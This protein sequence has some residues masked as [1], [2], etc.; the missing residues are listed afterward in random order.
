[1]VVP[2][3]NPVERVVPFGAADFSFFRLVRKKQ[4][5]EKYECK[6][7]FLSHKVLSVFKTFDDAS[8]T[9]FYNPA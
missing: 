7:R 5:E 6:L 4:Q 3:F 9:M 8:V 2:K 1:M